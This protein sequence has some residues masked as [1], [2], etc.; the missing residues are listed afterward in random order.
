MTESTPMQ[1][2]KATATLPVSI[3]DLGEHGSTKVI[4]IVASRADKTIGKFSIG[5]AGIQLFPDKGKG[6]P[7][8]ATWETI[9]ATLEKA[10]LPTSR[11]R[12]PP[13]DF[14]EQKV[15]A[16]KGVEHPNGFFDT[17]MSLAAKPIT[18]KALIAA[19][20]NNNKFTT[21]KDVNIV[22]RVRVRYALNHGFLQ[23]AK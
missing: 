2:S 4:M 7:K 17:V 16:A 6:E 10:P 15:V 8:R 3:L 9:R 14:Y 12:L 22:A 11:R 23:L 20:V 18:L 13:V 5:R 1:E 19:A 21:Q